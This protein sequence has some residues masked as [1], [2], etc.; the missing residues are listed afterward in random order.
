MENT[1]H[2]LAVVELKP[3][4][5]C[6]DFERSIAFYTTLG[7]EILWQSDE[8]CL[9]SWGREKFFLQN[10]YNQEAAENMMF[11]L[12]VENADHWY[13]HIETLDLK[14]KFGVQFTAVEDRE[15]GMR[16]F[17]LIDPSGV[18]WRIAHNISCSMDFV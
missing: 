3:F 5:P 12:Q 13:K 10:F 6:K 8:L 4:I 1:T 9:M 11:H 15:W 14:T 16:D 18:L 7:F 17:V 2:N